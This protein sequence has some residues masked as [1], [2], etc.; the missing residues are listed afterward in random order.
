[1]VLKGG[2][3]EGRTPGRYGGIHKPL[4]NEI[5]AFATGAWV[6]LLKRDEREIET[7]FFF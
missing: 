5:P 3:E 4:L 2:H 6:G 1:M 7:F